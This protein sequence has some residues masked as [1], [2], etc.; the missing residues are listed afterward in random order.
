[1]RKGKR[2]VRPL[3]VLVL[4]LAMA[5][6]LSL[7]GMTVAYVY[8]L[9]TGASPPPEDTQAASSQTG[10]SA[11]STS[12]P[13]T[14]APAT[15]PTT[16]ATTQ[17]TTRSPLNPAFSPSSL[18]SEIVL[19]V[20]ASD[21]EALIDQGGGETIYPASMTKIMTVLVAIENLDDLQ[22]EITLDESMYAFIYESSASVAGFVENESVRAI[23]LLYGAML[24]SGAEASIGLAQRIS[25]SEEA[26]V[27]LMNERAAEI[28]MED[29]HFTN[30]TGLHDEDHYTT[31]ADISLLVRR[32]VENE[33]FL[34]IFTTRRHSTAATNMHPDGITFYSTLF[35]HLESPELD[36]ATMLGGKTG[37]TSAAGQC[38]A[39]LAS[40]G[41][42]QY[43]L[44][45]AR[46]YGDPKEQQ[47]HIEDA[48][49]VFENALR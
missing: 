38:L 8:P 36:G 41:G 11:S 14:T 40:R 21:G 44:V 35:S 26:F 16:A 10:G 46:A 15:A 1:M 30:V 42:E 9:I 2:R 12:P 3:R 39:S 33:L 18:E 28:G 20:R 47:R 24:P 31:A 48:V 45:T 23:D 19:L 13:V 17:P 4:V 49:T 25:G 32:A 27:R 5:L 34:K 37:Y 6:V 22:E 7:A 29:S 43:V